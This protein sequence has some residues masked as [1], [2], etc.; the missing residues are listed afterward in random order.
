MAKKQAV[1]KYILNK[2]KRPQFQVNDIVYFT[3]LGEPLKGKVIRYAKNNE[4]ITYTIQSGRYKYPC[5]IQIKKHKSAKFG[6]VLYEKSRNHT[7]N[8]RKPGGEI[9]ASTNDSGSRGRYVDDTVRSISEKSGSGHGTKNDNK[10]GNTKHRGED[11][12]H[13]N[14]ASSDRELES[15]IDKQKQFL[16]GFT[17]K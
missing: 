6:L 11:K 8:I 13:T 1:P 4:D 14:P 7:G 9:D 16:R 17:K 2:F 10:L 5:G 12:S 15:A 3:W